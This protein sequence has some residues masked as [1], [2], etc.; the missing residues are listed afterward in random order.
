MAKKQ[1]RKPEM[2]TI[3]AG[4]AENSNKPGNDRGGGGR[5]AS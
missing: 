1:W 3:R 4:E 5:T 2:K